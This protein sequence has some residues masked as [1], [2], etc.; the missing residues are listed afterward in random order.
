MRIFL[1]HCLLEFHS[2]RDAS[3]R[4]AR[5]P[6]I[7]CPYLNRPKL[8]HLQILIAHGSVKALHICIL[9]QFAE[10]DILWTNAVLVRLL[11][12]LAADE[13]GNIVKA[14][15]PSGLRVI[16]SAN[17]GHEEHKASAGKNQSPCKHTRG[18]DHQSH[19]TFRT[20]P[21]YHLIRRKL[22]RQHLIQTL[23]NGQLVQ[24][25]P[26]RAGQCGLMRKC[27]PSDL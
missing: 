22:P 1:A 27:S 12:H 11:L 2:Q 16:Q 24:L 3:G 26:L 4:H 17:P 14:N 6:I 25:R 18:Y 15:H 19:K 13:L 23:W 5:P 7:I 21:V 9:L 8:V 10:L 20:G